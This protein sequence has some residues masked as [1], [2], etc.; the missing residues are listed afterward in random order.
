M[1][2]ARKEYPEWEEAQCHFI[3]GAHY[4]DAHPHWRSVEDEFPPHNQAYLAYWLHL[5]VGRYRFVKANEKVGKSFKEHITH[6][7]RLPQ[8]PSSSEKPN[9]CEKG[10]E[11]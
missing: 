1:Q 8:A 2:A 9:N 6:W 3:D 11:E 10:G 4:A 5:G 7:M